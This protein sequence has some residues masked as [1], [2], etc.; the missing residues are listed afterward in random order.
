MLSY[1]FRFYILDER[2]FSK[3]KNHVTF[4]VQFMI[5]WW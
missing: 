4:I 1:E 5:N 2:E 3:W